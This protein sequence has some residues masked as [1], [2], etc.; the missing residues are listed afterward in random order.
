[1][2][3]GA[4]QDPL[5]KSSLYDA[6][7]LRNNRHRHLPPSCATLF[8]EGSRGKGEEKEMARTTSRMHLETERALARSAGAPLVHGNHVRILRD[9]R[10][11]YPA[12]REAIR[13]AR[14][15]IY[16]ESY[17]LHEDAE[18]EIFADLLAGKARE[19]V[20]VRLIYDWLGALRTTSRRFWQRL[21]QA[22]V[23][24]RCFNPPRWDNGPLG[25]L[26][27]DHRKMILVDGE[28][29]YITGLC[30]GQMWAGDPAR[31]VEPWRDTGVELF[32][33]ALIDLERSFAEM[34]ALCGP[35]L[36][37]EELSSDGDGALAGTMSVRVIASMPNTASLYRM[38][39]LIAAGARETLW[40]TDA[41]FAGT[42]PY[43]QAMRAAAL[44]GVDVRLLVPQAS[45]IPGIRALS[46]AGY[47][48]LLEAGVRV[49]EWNGPMLHAKTAVADGH[50]AR[51][52]S[53]NLNLASWISN[54]ELDLVVENRHF[55]QAM[56]RMYLDDL[57][58]ATE[59]VL[60]SERR[61]R[62]LRPD[63]RRHL[64]RRLG[65]EGSSRAAA[66]A[67][68]IGRVVTAA[69]TNRRVLGP[70]EARIMAAGAGVLALLS[71]L[72]IFWPI[73]VA[74]PLALLGLW[75]SFTL[76]L[77]SVRLFREGRLR[78]EAFRSQAPPRAR[79]GESLS[80]KRETEKEVRKDHA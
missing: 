54:W 19:G 7:P 66:G 10:E 28:V 39:Q 50:W 13:Q 8:F 12:W 30:V 1:M 74:W 62:P 11:N 52:G 65:A 61:T 58:R 78:C 31:G 56:E 41:Y 14:R 16:F 42:T 72:A 48:T 60:T 44:D 59:I 37:E 6:F 38:D 32:G 68:R 43:V 55:G 63:L 5:R 46:R 18:G 33:P 23:E 77:R 57:E 79:D 53:T 75:I 47:R 25:W 40:L 27:R 29:G 17:I 70:A 76:C 49:F 2:E 3:E 9:A 69:I 36:P 20:V 64:H 35:P 34:W 22:G 45:D 73:A 67:L 51:V 4:R 80:E 71:L 24:V 26:G 15:K 21:R